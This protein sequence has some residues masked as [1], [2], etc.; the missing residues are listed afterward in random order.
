MRRRESLHLEVNNYSCVR[1]VPVRSVYLSNRSPHLHQG[2][3]QVMAA[4]HW[5]GGEYLLQLHSQW[6]KIP[7]FSNIIF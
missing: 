4:I 3:L 2:N 1:T 6:L 5:I 7:A